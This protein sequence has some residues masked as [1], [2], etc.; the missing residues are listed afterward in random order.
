MNWTV[1]EAGNV[2]LIHHSTSSLIELTVKDEE[3]EEK[4]VWLDYYDFSNLSKL[5]ATLTQE[6]LTIDFTTELGM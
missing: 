4:S 5:T 6:E 3:G 2:K 1:R